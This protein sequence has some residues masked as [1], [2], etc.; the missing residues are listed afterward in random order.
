MHIWRTHRGMGRQA[1]S[2]KPALPNLGTKKWLEI[3][4]ATSKPICDLPGCEGKTFESGHGLAIHNALVH[5]RR[6]LGV[7]SKSH[8]K[9]VRTT[10]Q[11][12]AFGAPLNYCPHCGFNLKVL[13]IAMRVASSHS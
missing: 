8:R 3:Q 7:K 10:D 5:S 13:G 9:I 2:S 1:E 4:K 6:G 12:E 11:P